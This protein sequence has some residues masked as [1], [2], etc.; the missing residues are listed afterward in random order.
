MHHTVQC[1]Y[2]AC[3]VH[4]QC[5]GAIVESFVVQCIY[6]AFWVFCMVQIVCCVVAT[7]VAVAAL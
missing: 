5:I 7:V 3:M 1:M 2:G 6:G 4:V